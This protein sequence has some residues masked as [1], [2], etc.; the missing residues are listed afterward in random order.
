[1]G[2]EQLGI[3]RTLALEAAR[4][5]N[6][7]LRKEHPLRQVFWESTVRC[8]IYCRHCGSDCRK[9]PPLPSLKGRES[10]PFKGELERVF[11][12]PREDFFRV[13][14]GL[15]KKQNPGE[16]DIILGG[17]EP[18]V[19]E[20][21]VECAKGIS[22]RG[23]PWGMVTNGLYLT[24]E[25]FRDLRRAGL[26]SITVSLD[27]LEEQHTWLRRHPDC[28]RMASQAIDMIVRDGTL[29]YDIMTC[30]HQHNYDTLPQLR[31]FLIGKGVKDW[32]LT[33][34]FPVGRGAQDKDLQLTGEQLKGLFGFIRETRREGK[35]H[36]SYGCEGF[37]GPYEGDVRDWMFRCSAGVTVASVLVDGGISACTSIRSNYRQGNI[38][39]DDF[40]DVW[41]HRF[42]PHRNHDWMKTGDCKDCRY[43]RYCE[44][45]GLHLRDDEGRLLLCHMKRME[46]HHQARLDDQRESQPFPGERGE[47]NG[48]RLNGK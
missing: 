46:P 48:K 14:D 41:E 26:C 31:D 21:V 28:F 25:M 42:Q 37:L 5:L 35:I 39:E 11:D 22:E 33:T 47:T 16:V 2:K 27:G 40:M 10:S 1:M 7:S 23:F 17:G 15:A 6:K 34:I 9:D 19:R 45:N 12:M 32:R 30:V 8:N 24:P 44:G 43:W 13:L 29:A 38:Y 20:D 4:L 36:A 3:R 18:L